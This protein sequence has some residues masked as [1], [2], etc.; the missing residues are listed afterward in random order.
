MVHVAARLAHVLPPPGLRGL[1]AS[2]LKNRPVLLIAD[3]GFGKT[4]ALRD[5]LDQT[6]RRAAWVRCG[7]AGGDAGR[8]LDLVMGAISEA[9]PGAVDVLA[10]RMTSARDPVDP[11]QAASALT[12]ELERLLVDP[13]V[14]C[15]DDAE[16][17]EGSPA[18]LQV[19]GRLIGSGNSLV[20]V[21]AASRRP[22][23]IRLARERACGRVAELG[24]ADLAFSAGECEA[25]L[26]LA[27]GRE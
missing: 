19:A 4:T 22:L 5:V 16:T 3:A 1:I 18:A 20:R 10:E 17:L 6:R 7:D 11:E 13:L 9:L 12:R 15:L 23:P 25:Y 27:Y 8:L 26:R 2:P 21:A 24:S 14:I